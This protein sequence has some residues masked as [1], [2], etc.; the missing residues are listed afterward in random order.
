[1][2]ENTYVKLNGHILPEQVLE[3]I[4]N[5]FDKNAKMLKISISNYHYNSNSFSPNATYYT[6][7]LPMPVTIKTDIYFEYK[8]ETVSLF[9]LYDNFN[10]YENLEYYSNHHLENMVKSETTFLSAGCY[11]D[12]NSIEIMKSICSVF[13]GWIDENDSD[14]KEY[15]WIPKNNTEN[16]VVVKHVTIEEVYEKFGCVVVID[17]F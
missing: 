8:G 7:M 3:F 11:E 10:Y 5:T 2:S 1:M 4:R 15:Y 6:E 16:P 12:G 17:N 9:Y 14:D 13:G